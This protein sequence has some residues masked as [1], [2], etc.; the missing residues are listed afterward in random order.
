MKQDIRAWLTNL[1]LGKYADAF[2]FHDVG[3]DVLADLTEE[4]LKELGVSLGNRLRLLRAIRDG[5]AGMVKPDQLPEGSDSPTPPLAE[6]AVSSPPPSDA[7]RRPLTVMFC[8]LADSTALST[9][10][11]P[12]D[13]QDVIRTYQETCTGL[14]REYGGYVAKYMGDGILVYFGYPKSLERNAERAVRSALGIVEAMTGLN[15]T[16]GRDKDFEIAVRIGIATGMVMVGEV[17][18]EGMAQERTV[19]GE[20][21]NMAA[22]LQGLAGRNGV[23]IGSLTKELSGDAFAYE[24]FGTHELKGITG[25]V[26]TW[27]VTG[28]RGDTAYDDQD[29]E[30]DETS[31]VLELVGRDEETGLLRRAWQSTKDE[32]RGQ[33][34]TISG[35]A[36]IGKSVLVDGL[37]AEVRA[38]GLPRLT[39]RCSPYHAGS[40]HYPVI[41]HFK[42]LADWQPDDDAEARLAKLEA[43]LGKYSQPLAETVPLIAS[44]LSLPLSGG[45][46]PAL[47]LSPQQQK[48]HTQDA[49]V[50][51]TLEIAERQP[52]LQL[53]EDLHWA[54]PSTLELIGLLIEQVP[55]AS[56]LMVLTAR[57][58]FVSPWPTR[59]HVTP[60]TLNRLERPHAEALVARIA[61]MKPLPAE[62]VD[63]V[64]TKTDG[65]PLYV[66]EL[67]KTILA[68]DILR[69]TGESYELTGP[70]SSLSIPDTLQESLMARLDRLPQ[71]RELA[72]LGSV[73]GREFAYEMISGLSTLGDTLLQE[74]LSQLVETELLYQRGRPPRARYI[75]KHALV[76]DA[77]YG[78]L[79]RRTRQQTHLQV[80]EL[81]ENRFLETAEAHPELL[82]HHLGE[83]GQPERAVGYWLKAGKRAAKSSANAEAFASYMQGLEQVAL[84]SEGMDRDRLELDLQIALINPIIAFKGYSAPETKAASERATLLCRQT[85]QES[86]VFEAIY[87]QLAYSYVSAQISRYQELAV[88]YLDLANGQQEVAHRAVGHRMV[89]TASLVAGSL[90]P[91]VQHLEKAWALYDPERDAGSALVYGQDLGT[92]TSSY[93][94]LASVLCGFPDQGRDWGHKAVARGQDVNHANTLGFALLHAILAAFVAGDR[95]TVEQHLDQLQVLIDEHDLPVWRASALTQQGAVLGWLGLPQDGLVKV[96]QGFAMMADMQ[97]KLFRPLFSLIRAGLLTELGRSQ[98]ALVTIT[99]ALAATAE[100]GERWTEA[101]L[102]RVRGELLLS[103][104]KE[105]EAEAA[106]TT[107]LTIAREQGAKWWE[108]RAATSIARLWHQQIR[109]VEARDTLSG[110]YGWFTEGFDTAD[111]K[112]AK[113]LLIEL[114]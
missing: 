5:A 71:V 33:V 65:V 9:R 108:L 42:R 21:P 53:W 52:H 32:G 16:L 84:L 74:G 97:F 8:D 22:R 13:L 28:L 62:V 18:G 90:T 87:G 82:A 10:L 25:L 34:V 110:V 78:S 63:H 102:H 60:I 2:F 94:G 58:E 103:Q 112:E 100:T 24:D 86:R 44:I 61:G 96:E 92:A 30:T 83:A 26:H 48:Q 57:P 40:A 99:D 91:A 4:H 64:V 11:D 106:F 35:E 43:M 79:L 114:A 19:I 66:E 95:A 68:S 20:A 70:L 56:L 76:Q 109:L 1:G 89:G 7:E 49:I 23:V 105:S 17:V 45:R 3:T 46:Y 81:M 31:A 73:L 101:E 12:E 38:E 67:T 104:F 75:F 39:L 88:E 14:I 50:A 107:A 15:R 69:D 85:G 80:A 37:K 72:Q 27:S 47:T 59:S 51:M 41:E 113:A 98:D 6:R 93:L 36:G 55:T 111:L 29:R 54:D 77:A